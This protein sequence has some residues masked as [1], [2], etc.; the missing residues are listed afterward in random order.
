MDVSSAVGTVRKN[1]DRRIMQPSSGFCKGL[2][3]KEYVRKT[4]T[5]K[6]YSTRALPT[7]LGVVLV[8][9][10]RNEEKQS[11]RKPGRCDKTS[12]CYGPFRTYS[13]SLYTKATKLYHQKHSFGT[14]TKIHKHQDNFQSHLPHPISSPP[15][16]SGF[17]CRASLILNT[18]WN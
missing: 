15:S 4:P 11:K 16:G 6:K 17:S 9:S 12:L 14:E 10:G 13:K 7:A 3:F 8:S 2:G 1:W 18:F 5:W